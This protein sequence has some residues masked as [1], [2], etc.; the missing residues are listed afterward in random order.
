VR[1]G[2]IKIGTVEKQ[3]LDKHFR[4]VLTFRIN[5]DIP[6]PKDTSVAIHT[7]GLFG[8]KFV[9]LEPGGDETNLK[10]GDMINFAQ[11][12]V[13][14]SE[15]LELIIAQGKDN[16]KQLQSQKSKEGK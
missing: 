7:D 2:G 13:I 6:L 3:T 11:G 4:A 8:S 15:L 16:L 14:L 1:L 10:D 5:G 9:V 12:A